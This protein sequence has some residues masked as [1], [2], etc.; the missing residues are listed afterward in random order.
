MTFYQGI[1]DH[2]AKVEDKH[3]KIYMQ[4]AAEVTIL[5]EGFS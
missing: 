3:A 1:L 2:N 4:I 5:R